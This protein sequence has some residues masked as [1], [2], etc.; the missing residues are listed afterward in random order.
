VALLAGCAVLPSAQRASSLTI[1]PNTLSTRFS[2]SGRFSAKTATDQVSGQFRYMQSD[3]QRT[4]NLFSPVGTPLA[5][6]VA[7]RDTASLTQA[8]GSTQT[9]ASLSALLRTVIDLPVTDDMVSAW[10]QGLPSSSAG[11]ASVSGTER[12]AIGQLTG[13]SEGGWRIEISAR[14]EAAQPVRINANAPRRMRWS[15]IALPDTEV[16][17][18]ID[19]WSTP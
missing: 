2:L 8:S 6:I 7:G 1:A 5:D 15:F 11:T 19:E 9:A 4:L 10:L 18:V 3:A 12:D 16:R 17:W 13:F 14:M